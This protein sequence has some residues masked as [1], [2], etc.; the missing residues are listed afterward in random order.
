[1]EV[2]GQ[3]QALA[4]LLPEYKVRYAVY[5][6][7]GGPQDRSGRVRKITPPTGFD[8]QT[9]QP[10]VSSR[11]TDCAF[12]A[13]CC[14]LVW[15]IRLRVVLY[16]LRRKFH[17]L[18]LSLCLSLSLSHSPLHFTFAICLLGRGLCIFFCSSGRLG[19]K[20]SNLNVWWLIKLSRLCEDP[21]FDNLIEYMKPVKE[22]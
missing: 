17:W 1:M 12:P 4:A 20:P 13:H 15:S 2:G 18:P 16:L 14:T 7:L 8:P 3:R 21:D 11:Y 19:I 6:R 9:I 22:M 5:R 10:V